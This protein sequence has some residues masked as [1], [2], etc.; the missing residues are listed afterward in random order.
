[1]DI[2][3][4]PKIR[5][6]L[7][8][9]CDHAQG[10]RKIA[11][12]DCDG[13]VIRGDIGEAMFYRQIREFLFRHSPADIWPD[14]P[15]RAELGRLFNL[16]ERLPKEERLRCREFGTF[17]D[18]LLTWYHGQIDAGKV[19]K[20]CADIV[21]LFAG[22][23]IEEVRSIANDNFLEEINIPFTEDELGSQKV[24]RGLRFLAQP[25]ALLRAL[26][27]HGFDVWAVSGSDKFAVEPVFR[28]LGVP[29]ERVIGIELFDR[30][31]VLLPE[32]QQ[33]IPIRE[34]KIVALEQRTGTKPL[35]AASDSRN[36]IPLL[37]S[38]TELRILVNSR[39]RPS[40]DFFKLGGAAR[41]A[42]WFVIESPTNLEE[43]LSNG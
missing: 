42:S 15:K 35:I 13:T 28:A 2:T 29:A 16:L 5:E 14:H 1:M 37:L 11:V 30:S 21:S 32:A 41:D 25:V 3:Q 26:Q 8:R 24:P 17:A 19:E 23:T 9:H 31:G 36:D 10:E 6:F 39:G 43:P 34:K 22:F 20:A 27:Q 38:A 7:Q 33:P 40:T 18:I 12:F 4:E